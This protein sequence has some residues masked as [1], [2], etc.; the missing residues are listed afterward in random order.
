MATTKEKNLNQSE[1]EPSAS[2]PINHPQAGY[3]SPDLSFHDGTGILPEAEKAWHEARNKAQE[4]GAEAVAEQETKADKE[5]KEAEEEASKRA[6]AARDAQVKK[7][8]DSG[9]IAEPTASAGEII[10]EKQEKGSKAS[11]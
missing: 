5:I 1:E 8:V 9:Q 6:E 11:S 10:A 4:E 7:Q 3:V 2:L